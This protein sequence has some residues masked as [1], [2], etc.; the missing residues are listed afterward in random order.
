MKKNT[1][2]LS[3]IGLIGI[4]SSTWALPVGFDSSN[5]L[6]LAHLIQENSPWVYLTI[7]FGL[8]VLLAFT[9][10]VLPMVPILSGI[11]VGQNSLSLS[12]AFKLSAAYVIGMALTY[13]LAGMLAA[14]LGSTVQTL[15]QQP[16]II[17]TFSVLFILMALSMLDIFHLRLP[18][19][20][21][22]RLSQLSQKSNNKS[23]ISVAL[24]G[25]ISTLIVSPCVT[26]PLI[27]VLTY[28]GQEGQVLKGGLILF[29]MALGMG[30]PLLLV[31]AGYGSLLPNT[32]L[33]MIK[34][35]QFFGLLMLGMAIWM[36]S[37]ILPNTI[38]NV[39]WALLLIMVSFYLGLFQNTTSNGQRVM[40]IFGSLAL[41]ISGIMLYSLVPT[42]VKNNANANT[43]TI[44]APKEAP[45][46]KVNT[47]EE[48]NAQ[49]IQA[50]QAHK[51][52]F[53]EFYAT[54]CSDCQAMEAHVF[55]QP[56]I[57]KTMNGLVSLKVNLS[58]NTPETREIKKKF[59]IYG[60]PEMIFFD[61]LGAERS[62]LTSAGYLNK[63][64]MLSLL[65]K[66]K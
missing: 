54:W 41:M 11:I 37:R 28:I 31:G 18:S 35:K 8:G 63:A 38:I 42:M 25:V 5:P 44:A 48:I 56:D 57:I 55:N 6:T 45:F 36:L 16:W 14:Y 46:I 62:G 59:A 20:F 27:G 26:A 23:F 29:V 9:P 39:L 51:P 1:Y 65:K 21:N 12:R 53:L 61:S 66:A 49:L 64:E 7:F 34:I 19:S 17:G 50:K 33:W 40:Q 58:D 32:G 22:S 4:V 47:L 60:L 3:L 24:M 13:A 15:M 10:C 52:V 30:T 2:L 43:H